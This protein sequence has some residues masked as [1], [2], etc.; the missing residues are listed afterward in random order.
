MIFFAFHCI[1]IYSI[2]TKTMMGKIAGQWF[3]TVQVSGH[4]SLC[5][6]EF[7]KMSHFKISKWK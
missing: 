4:L 7:F 6:H 3:W 5:N 1:Y 2:G